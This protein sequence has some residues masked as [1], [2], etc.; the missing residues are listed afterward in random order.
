MLLVGAVILAAFVLLLA[1]MLV[2]LLSESS[3]S[4]P[5]IL[6]MRKSP[7]LLYALLGAIGFGLAWM[8]IGLRRLLIYALLSMVI[9]IGGHLLD[10]PLFVPLLLL[11]GAILA[12]GTVLLVSFLRRSPVAEKENHGT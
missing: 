4:S 10:L 1:G 9:M 11:G 7:S 2:L 5:L 6:E 12:T 8:I 3:S